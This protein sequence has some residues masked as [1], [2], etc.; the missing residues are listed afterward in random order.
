MADWPK[1]QKEKQAPK[2]CFL[3]QKNIKPG[4]RY[5]EIVKRGKRYFHDRCYKEALQNA[6]T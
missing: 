1:M 2:R 4:E 6:D 3:C 5:H